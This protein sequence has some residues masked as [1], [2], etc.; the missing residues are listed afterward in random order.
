MEKLAAML[1]TAGST[2]FLPFKSG[3]KVGPLNRGLL[4]AT[5]CFPFFLLAG[6]IQHARAIQQ[7]EN[8]HRGH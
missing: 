7:D 6:L 8:T 4:L 1:F 3:A 5:T 2:L